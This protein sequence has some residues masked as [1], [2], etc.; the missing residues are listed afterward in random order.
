MSAETSNKEFI[1]GT[2]VQSNLKE[3]RVGR[4]YFKGR[5]L[6]SAR[7][8]WRKNEEEEW[9]PGSGLTFSFEDIDELI[10]FL[11][12]LKE[13]LE[14][15]SVGQYLGKASKKVKEEEEITEQEDT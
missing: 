1:A 7:K 11:G 4:S 3:I 15:E 5:E 14:D 2:I 10:E 12:V 8:W 13:K 9:L 6:L